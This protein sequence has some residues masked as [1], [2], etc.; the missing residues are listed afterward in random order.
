MSDY[1]GII[2]G[3]NDKKCAPGKEF[4]DG[5]CIDVELLHLMAL[6]Y[7]ESMKRK[8]N[9]YNMIN[10]DDK[11][12][13]EK[14]REY[15]IRLLKEFSKKMKDT[16]G[17]EDQRCWIEQNYVTLILN[18]A[19]AKINKKNINTLEEL[20]RYTFPPL[21]PKCNEWLSTRDI[22]DYFV[23][24]MR[25]DPNFKFF[26]A[27]PR[28]FRDVPLLG[29]AE[30]NFKKLDNKGMHKLGIVFNL[31]VHTESGSHW[32]MLYS[33]VK[34]GTIYFVDSYGA[35]PNKEFANLMNDLKK[36][37]ESKGIKA[38]MRI[39]TFKH[40]KSNSECGMY[41]IYFINYFRKGG[42]FDNINTERVPDKLVY[43]LRD[44]YFYRR[45]SK[46]CK[47]PATL[48]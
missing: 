40:Q 11:K 6:S 39:G 35:K 48:K 43:S 10:T 46:S 38:D 2:I 45:D 4:K 31:D 36:Y 21:G 9:T 22:E 30:I 34:K 25:V 28:D 14:P 19:D 20:T 41:S 23:Q 44:K 3:P 5:S 12:L 8:G 13:K 17:C 33:D 1:S 7:N 26:G 29:L 32:V 18:Y 15:K 24:I 27:V 37:I 42:S 47:L 16:Y